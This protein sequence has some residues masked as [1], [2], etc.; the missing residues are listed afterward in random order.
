MKKLLTIKAASKKIGVSRGTLYQWER[1]R[2]FRPLKNHLG[3][4]FYTTP[5]INRLKALTT[6]K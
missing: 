4:R 5:M 1:K 2:I 6:P 3:W